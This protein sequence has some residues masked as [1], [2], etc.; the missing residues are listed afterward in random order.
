M[1]RNTGGLKRIRQYLQG[2]GTHKNKH[3]F[4]EK[5]SFNPLSY[6][7][8]QGVTTCRPRYPDYD[9]I[10]QHMMQLSAIILTKINVFENNFKHTYFSFY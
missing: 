5:I 8:L 9:P 7:K 1:A 6:S 2:D 4:K 3:L 10:V